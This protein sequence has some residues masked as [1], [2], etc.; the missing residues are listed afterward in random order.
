MATSTTDLGPAATN[1]AAL[2]EAGETYV[3]DC[4][5]TVGGAASATVFVQVA[6]NCGD[7]ASY[8]VLAG[9]NATAGTSRLSQAPPSPPEAA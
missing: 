2:V 3:I 8:P 5:V 1:I 9:G 4:Q 7:G 6:L